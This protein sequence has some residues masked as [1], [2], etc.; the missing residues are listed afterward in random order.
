MGV[1]QLFDGRLKSRQYRARAHVVEVGEP[2]PLPL[3]GLMGREP[4]PH[5]KRR[6]SESAAKMVK[7]AVEFAVHPMILNL[8]GG[9]VRNCFVCAPAVDGKVS[10]TMGR[11]SLLFPAR[12]ITRVTGAVD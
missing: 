7:G 9:S 4:S 11:V 3:K 2:N 5:A 10:V 8:F 6:A 12:V 1:G